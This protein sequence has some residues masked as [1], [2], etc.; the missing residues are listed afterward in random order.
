MCLVGPRVCYAMAQD[1]GFFSI[2]TR[3]HPRW[4]SPWVAVA[5]QGVVTVF[6]IVIPTF[7]GLVIYIGF[8]LYLF[9]ALAVLGLFKFRQRPDWKRF[10]W[11]DRAYPFVPLLYVGMSG[12]ILIFSIR[13]A[14]VASGMALATV[15]AGALGYQC[16]NSRKPAVDP[17]EATRIQA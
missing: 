9:T 14:P 10:P 7:R 17:I 8:M 11:L 16:I 3:V 15:L 5:I 2:A 4:Q 13:G 6:L 12:W 1:G